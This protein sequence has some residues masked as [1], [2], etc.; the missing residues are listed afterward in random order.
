V[1][2]RVNRVTK[3]GRCNLSLESIAL[4]CARV[5]REFPDARFNAQNEDW[6]VYD[7][8]E[9]PFIQAI[10]SRESLESFSAVAQNDAPERRL[11]LTFDQ[12]EATAKLVA[13][14][15]Q[16]DWFRHFLIDIEEYIRPKSLNEKFILWWKWNRDPTSPY[17]RIAIRKKG[18]SP[19]LEGIKVNLASNVI[20]F[21]LGFVFLALLGWISS[22][23]GVDINPFDVSVP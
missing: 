21:I 1:P 4:I 14:E 5:T 10:S 9:I 6:E 3:L 19:Y 16:L 18:P 20:W 2:I 22:T 13:G 23:I 11:E 17:S 7:E 8:E 15:D 12:K